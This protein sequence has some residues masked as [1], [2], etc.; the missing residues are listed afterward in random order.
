MQLVK[1]AFI[2]AVIVLVSVTEISFA[3]KNTIKNYNSMLENNIGILDLKTAGCIALRDSPSIKAAKTKIIIATQ[4]YNQVKA[5][6]LPKVDLICSTLK[7]TVSDIDY[8]KNKVQ[9]TLLG[10]TTDNPTDYYN[11]GLSASWILFN[12]F[13][14]EFSVDGATLGISMSKYGGKDA[15]RNLLFAV[16]KAYFAAQL[17]KENIEITIADGLFYKRLLE[18]AKVRKIAGAGSLSDELSFEVRLN[19]ANA[20]FLSA[21]QEYSATL[22]KLAVLLGITNAVFP[23]Q[24][25]LAELKYENYERFQVEDITTLINYT[26]N[27]RPDILQYKYAIEKAAAEVSIVRGKFMPLVWID[28]QIKGIHEGDAKIRSDDFG[29]SVSLNFSYNI[30]SGGADSAAISK[31]RALQLEK[32]LRYKNLKLQICSDVKN[33]FDKLESAVK[34]YKLY[35]LNAS[36]VKQNRDLIEIEYSAGKCSLVRLNEAQRDLSMTKNREALALVSIFQAKFQLEAYTG[37]I[38]SLF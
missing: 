22:S 28:G 38:L 34:R 24:A 3:S 18:D 10:S 21:Q 25:R 23:E 15:A 32:E 2:W 13:Q 11:A 12:G 20:E 27:N 33:S 26:I 17:A 31:A 5:G 19:T 29:H 7:K 16:S 14:R 35:N 30:F 6:Y 1:I 8:E 37:G 4:K 36:L 9:A